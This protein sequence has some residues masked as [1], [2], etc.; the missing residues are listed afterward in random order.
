MMAYM[1]LLLIIAL[2]FASPLTAATKQKP[3]PIPTQSEVYLMEISLTEAI[4]RE[5]AT[6]GLPALRHWIVLTEVARTHSK[7]MASGAVPFGHDGFKARAESIK[8]NYSLRSFGENV[9]YSHHVADPLTAAVTGWMKS[10]GHRDNILGS[11]I[12]TGIGISF[13]AEGKCYIT[14]LFATRMR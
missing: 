3:T 14:Q 9:A 10:Q 11:F 12:E 7:N 2:L 5:R 4:N 1:K 6:Y 8:Q 13:S